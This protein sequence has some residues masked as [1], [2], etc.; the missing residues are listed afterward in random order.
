[1]R[2]LVVEFAVG[3]VLKPTEAAEDENVGLDDIS[4][5]YV[6]HRDTFGLAEAP[7]GACIL[8]ALSCNLSDADLADP[9]RDP[10]ADRWD[11]HVGGRR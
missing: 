1:M 4:T 11:R 2:R 10:D 7:I 3:R 5:Y 9:I 6:L 8:Y